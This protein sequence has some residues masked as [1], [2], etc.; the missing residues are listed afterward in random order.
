MLTIKNLSAKTGDTQILKGVNLD[1]QAGSKHAIMGPNG[2]GK[3]TLAKVLS[4]H[5]DY[6]VTSGEAWLE[7]TK[8]ERVNLLELEAFE[9]SLHGLFIGFQYPVEVPGVNNLEF[10]R[11]SFN[12]LCEFH[13][14][15]PLDEEEF[16]VFIAEKTS[17]LGF[18]EPFLARDLNA[19]LSGGEK[20]RN[21]IIQLSVLNP[22]LAVMDETDSGLDVDALREVGGALNN[23]HHSENAYIMV[24]HYERLLEIV[25]PDFVHV[26][27]DGKIIKT[28]DR[29]I[30]KEIDEKGY[31]WLIEKGQS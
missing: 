1:V 6:E 17:S 7:G 8:G 23:L 20:K 16:K 28:A 22:K 4:G 31:D 21:E 10:L 11:A 29:S 18:G 26:F 24:T 9:R 12:S 30:V 19:D 13:G 27:H 25:K 3:S 14:S 2:S 5:P 15:A